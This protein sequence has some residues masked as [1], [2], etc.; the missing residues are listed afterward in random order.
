M[1]DTL[2]HQQWYLTMLGRKPFIKTIML[3]QVISFLIAGTGFFASLLS[4]NSVS[5]PVFLMALNYALL[6]PYL[7]FRSPVNKDSDL[8]IPSSTRSADLFYC[9]QLDLKCPLWL[10]I[11]IS[12]I[13]L[14]ANVVVISAYRYTTIT[15]I[16]LLD[17]FS[18]PCVMLLSY[19]FLNAKYSYKHL[20][21]TIICLAGMAVII[22][23]DLQ[24]SDS[25]ESAKD[26]VYGDMLCLV[27]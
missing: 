5:V 2:C 14:E 13:D 1:E 24:N 6:A 3:G 15:S 12:I 27:R 10:Y 8:D 4:N 21:G 16:M 17:C 19:F 7:F 22:I 18:I 23:S 9:P 26:P 20:G 11:A 25:T